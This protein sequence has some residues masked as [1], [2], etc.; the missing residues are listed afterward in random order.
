[1]NKGCYRSTNA[2][3][4][5]I[6]SVAL[7]CLM[8]NCGERSTKSEDAGGG[9]AIT[10]LV[11]VPSAVQ[12]GRSAVVDMVVQDDAGHPLSGVKVSFSVSPSNIGH[13]SPAV[14]T[15]DANGSAGTVFTAASPGAAVIRAGIEGVTSKTVPVEVVAPTVSTKP[16]TIEITPDVLP[17]DGISTGE[18]EV[19]VRDTSGFLVE[20]GTVVKFTAGEKFDDL[21]EDG[22]FTEGV[23]EL[24]YDVNQD[25]RWNPIGFVPLY[26]LTDDGEV[27][28]T[29]VAGLRTGTAYI[30]VT[31]NLDG[32]L[33]QDEA[34]L[35]LVPTDSVAYIVLMPDQPVIQVRGTGGVEATQIRAICYDDNGN[36]VGAD[37]PVEFYIMFGPDGGESLNGVASDSITIKTNSYGEATVTLSS[38]TKSGP[39]KLRA[40]VGTM[41]SFSTIVT[42]CAGPPVDISLSPYYCNIPGCEEDCVEDSIC[43][44]VVDRYGNPVPDSTSV[45]FGTEEGMVHPSDKTKQG[46]AYSLYIS[47]DPRNDC[48]ALVWAETWG[49]DGII[50]DTCT[51]ILSGDPTSV[52]FLDYPRTILAD[53][54]SEGHVL[55]EVLDA[56]DYFVVDSTPVQ[57]HSV[58]GSVASGVTKDGCDASLFQTYLISEVLTQDYS[59]KYTDRDDSIGVVSLLTAKCGVESTTVSVTFLTGTTYSKKCLVHVV[60]LIPQG[61]TVPVVV[62]VKDAYGNPLGGHYIVGDQA[63]SWKG[64]I[65]GSAYTNEFG[66]ATGFYFTATNLGAGVIA[67]YDQDPKG[68]VCIAFNV[69]IVP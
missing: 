16:L 21:D 69:E 28:V 46:C 14:D 7:V 47:G 13:C 31:T 1:M 53:G 12:E 23:D 19:T 56:N 57:M 63:R 66:E 5:L 42:I 68:G 3:S 52:T 27:T 48:I 30:K 51:I 32:Y 44:C 62:F 8:M 35:L 33:I 22:Y 36:R 45:Y 26:A 4:W 54:I 40:K 58:F 18:I 11:V 55:I 64:T 43:A 65:T 34:T 20:D 59:M 6:V 49:E 67:F 29:Y 2:I 15:T 39:V 9:V 24:K 61:A 37:F 41:L 38:G 17:A 50:R 10:S 25:G 60:P